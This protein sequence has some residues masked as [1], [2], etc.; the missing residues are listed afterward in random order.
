M[1]IRKPKLEHSLNR[2]RRCTKEGD[3][4]EDGAE[5]TL[6]HL[7]QAGHGVCVFIAQS[8][9]VRPANLYAEIPEFLSN[10]YHTTCT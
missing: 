2:D 1:C 8:V 5:T 4:I 7:K 9:V 6:T 3:D 10:S